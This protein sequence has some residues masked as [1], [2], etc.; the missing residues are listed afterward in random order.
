MTIKIN[1]QPTTY[2]PRYIWTLAN[3]P[4]FAEISNWVEVNNGQNK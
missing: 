2:I 4:R 1:Y 3:R